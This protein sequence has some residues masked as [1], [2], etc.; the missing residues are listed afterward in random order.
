MTPRPDDDALARRTDE[1]RAELGLETYDRD[2]VPA[3][4]DATPD[5]DPA[6]DEQYQEGRAEVDRESEEGE[7]YPL[8]A[9][10]P[11]PPSHY[12]KS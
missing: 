1:E 9:E 6:E 5:Y 3:A 12:D 11:D 8:T 10:H 4:S 2:E 7:L